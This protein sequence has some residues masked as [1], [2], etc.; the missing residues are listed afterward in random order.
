M[1]AAK[2]IMLALAIFGGYGAAFGAVGASICPEAYTIAR[3]PAFGD[4]P[5]LLLGA[6]WGLFDFLPFAAGVGIG[7]GF[8][9]HIG[10]RPAVKAFFFRRPMLMLLPMIAA[11]GTVVGYFCYRAVVSGDI[12]VPRNSRGLPLDTIPVYAAT[13][14]AMIASHA[15][16]LVGGAGLAVWTWCKRAVFEQMVK[17]NAAKE[18]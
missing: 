16:M 11:V 13:W 6:L 10:N 8:A 7:I 12:P 4:L 3:G 15:T 9:A 2:I 1:E 14:W 18:R 5:V 17:E